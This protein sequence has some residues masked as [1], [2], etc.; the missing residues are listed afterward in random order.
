MIVMV[1]ASSY[2]FNSTAEKEGDAEVRLGFEFTYL[3]HSGSIAC[4]SFFISVITIIKYTLLIIAQKTQDFTGDTSISRCFKCCGNCIVMQL[5]AICDYV[6]KT[7]YSYIAVSGENFCS[8]A[9]NGFLLNMKHALE[10]FWA[11][12]LAKI[13]IGLGKFLLVALNCYIFFLFLNIT[14][15][16]RALT[17][18]YLVPMLLVGFFTYM[19]TS[20]FLGIFDEV[21]LSL[22]TCMC[23]DIELNLKPKYGPPEF[24]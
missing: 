8:S 12:F 4:G 7:A 16:M 11:N 17:G 15:E 2:Y 20:I 24:H 18:T 3:K 19:S 10:F 22:L 14:G 9:W 6:N 1:S 13:F 5:D 23:I 21:V